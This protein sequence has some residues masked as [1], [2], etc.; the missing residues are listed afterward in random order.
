MKLQD[1]QKYAALLAK[2]YILQDEIRKNPPN[3]PQEYLAS[4]TEIKNLWTEARA[5]VAS[6]DLTPGDIQK[7]HAMNQSEWVDPKPKADEPK[8]DEP[9]PT[10]KPAGDLYDKEYALEPEWNPGFQYENGST[11]YSVNRRGMTTYIMTRPDSPMPQIDGAI[12]RWIA[13]VQH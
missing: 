3:D 10:P 4:I 13:E 8:P 5:L 11:L 6:S 2:I 12:V 7:A 1:I 9:T